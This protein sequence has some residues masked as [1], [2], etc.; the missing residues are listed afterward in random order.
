MPRAGAK[1]DGD[2]LERTR[3]CIRA[4]VWLRLKS[5]ISKVNTRKHGLPLPCSFS[6]FQSSNDVEAF[7]LVLAIR[8]FR[9]RSKIDNINP[10]DRLALNLY[11]NQQPGCHENE[12]IRISCKD[13]HSA[14]FFRR[15]HPHRLPV[16]PSTNFVTFAISVAA[17][18][19]HCP[20]ASSVKK[21]HPEFTS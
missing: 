16:I 4:A 20:N 19:H 21:T 1:A 3:L 7:V 14:Y 10:P 6:A 11:N 15:R 13:I 18:M 5:R 8:P 9:R 2:E 17:S 12:L